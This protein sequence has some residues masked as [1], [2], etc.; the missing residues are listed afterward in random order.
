MPA[1]MVVAKFNRPSLAPPGG[2]QVGGLRGSLIIERSYSI[3][4][5][6]NERFKRR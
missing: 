3:T 1:I 6:L 5:F 2:H 4:H